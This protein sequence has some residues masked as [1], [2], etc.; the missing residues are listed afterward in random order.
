M[1]SVKVSGSSF[2]FL[3]QLG[4]APLF[5][6]SVVEAGVLLHKFRYLEDPPRI[7]LKNSVEEKAGSLE[8]VASSCAAFW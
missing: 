6:P 7:R 5:I 2:H 4:V 8:V 1:Q 3:L